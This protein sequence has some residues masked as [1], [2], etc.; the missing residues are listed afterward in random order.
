MSIPWTPLKRE[1]VPWALGREWPVVVALAL[2]WLLGTRLQCA[3]QPDGAALVPAQPLYA[4]PPQLRLV[5]MALT[6]V[7]LSLW[8]PADVAF[9]VRIPHRG[10]PSGIP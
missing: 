10:W 2:L 7:L 9:S 5:T 4:P 1:Q 6:L 3:S 8:L